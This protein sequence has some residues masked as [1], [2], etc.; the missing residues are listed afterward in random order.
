[1]LTLD[2]IRQP[3]ERAEGNCNSTFGGQ[4][5][6]Q[7]CMSVW[8]FLPLLGGEKDKKLKMHG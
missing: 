1:M 5:M 2:R 8:D 4:E 6:K 7:V 3:D